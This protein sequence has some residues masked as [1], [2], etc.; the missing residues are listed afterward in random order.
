[1]S[2]QLRI[3]HFGDSI[4]AGQHVDR[5]LCWT[6]LIARRLG[7]R[8]TS[9]NRGVPGETATMGLERLVAD[10]EG[11]QP[12]LVTLQFGM[13]D[14]NCWESDAGAPRASEG[15][16]RQSV[17]KMICLAHDH[18]VQQVVLATNPCSLRHHTMLS[19]ES[20]ES[21]NRSYSQVIKEIADQSKVLLCDIRA[22]FEELR[23]KDLAAMLL[24]DNLHLS[25]EGHKYYAGLMLSSVESAIH[26]AHSAQTKPD[27]NSEDGARATALRNGR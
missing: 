13:N 2:N 26:E 5:E 22:S 11:L 14:C 18:G 25:E 8:C 1:M 16:F 27:A 10:L 15:E 12:E 7:D 20:Y 4:T 21:A 3:M 9:F 17:S 6:T 19:G 24:P 23:G